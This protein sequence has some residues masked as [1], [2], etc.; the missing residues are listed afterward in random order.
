MTHT[1]AR[2]AD[3]QRGPGVLGV[4]AGRFPPAVPSAVDDIAVELGLGR[5]QVLSGSGRAGAAQRWRDGEYGPHSA[6]AR[7]V[8]RVCRD[9]A[10]YLPLAGSLGRMF[11]ICANEMSADGHVV[12]AEYGCGAHSDTPAPAGNGSPRY[13]PFDDGV[14][15]LL[16]NQEN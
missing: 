9:C 4:V 3:P 16:E 14:L 13:D 1:Q 6:M 7:S 15:D 8:R 10:F 11:G 12:D 5:R 2:P